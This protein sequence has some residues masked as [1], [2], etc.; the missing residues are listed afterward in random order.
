M[1]RDTE[2]QVLVDYYAS[3]QRRC[4]CLRKM[5]EAEQCAIRISEL[6]K[7]PCIQTNT[8]VSEMLKRTHLATQHLNRV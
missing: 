3:R 1:L 5:E 8:S 7:L 2:I 4:I 6:K